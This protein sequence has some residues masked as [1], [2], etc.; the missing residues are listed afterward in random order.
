[1]KGKN[2]YNVKAVF[3]SSI[4]FVFW[5][6]YVIVKVLFG[7]SEVKWFFQLWYAFLVDANDVIYIINVIVTVEYK[8]QFIGIVVY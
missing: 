1:M 4:Y 2:I 8:K 7:G 6:V 5:N 3:K